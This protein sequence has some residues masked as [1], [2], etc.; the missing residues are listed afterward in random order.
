M[1]TSFDDN[2]A[3]S[4]GQINA[5]HVDWLETSRKEAIRGVFSEQGVFTISSS[6]YKS[7]EE[8]KRT[9]R[10]MITT[11]K[12]LDELLSIYQNLDND[13]TA[14]RIKVTKITRSCSVKKF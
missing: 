9:T 13:V 8:D 14:T 12:S 3:T 2:P 7:E 5:D 6:D 10:Q 1:I 11:L 4:V